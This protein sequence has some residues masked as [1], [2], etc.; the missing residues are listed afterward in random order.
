MSAKDMLIWKACK[1]SD[2]HLRKGSFILNRKLMSIW[3]LLNV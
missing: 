3:Y 2:K 1:T